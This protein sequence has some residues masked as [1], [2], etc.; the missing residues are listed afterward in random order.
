MAVKKTTI[1][2]RLGSN[3]YEPLAFRGS[4]KVNGVKLKKTPFGT[5]IYDL[6]EFPDPPYEIV[7]HSPDISISCDFAAESQVDPTQWAINQNELTIEGLPWLKPPH[8][9]ILVKGID[10]IGIEDIYKVY[11]VVKDPPI[12]RSEKVEAT[13]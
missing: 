5:R 9:A 2:I 8:N 12:R 6:T 11:F 10:V 1:K 4:M 13:K 3:E 7:Y